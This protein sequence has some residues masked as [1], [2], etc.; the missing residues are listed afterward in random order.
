MTNSNEAG[1]V[2]LGYNVIVKPQKV[3]EKR[4]SIYIPEAAQDRE[5]FRQ[6]RGKVI[7]L[8]ELAF[9]LGQPGSDHWAFRQS[10][11]VGDWVRYHEYRGQRFKHN[12]EVY[13]H[14]K[15]SEILAIETAEPD[16][17][18]NQEVEV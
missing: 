16:T 3:E 11:E 4:G 2:P 9:T 15:D 1:V 6:S 10:P 18:W 8:G 13:L 17:D 5:G 14:L 12:G 7:A